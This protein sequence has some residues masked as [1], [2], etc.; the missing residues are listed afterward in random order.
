VKFCSNVYGNCGKRLKHSLIS[1][2]CLSKPQINQKLQDLS[3]FTN[4]QKR[5]TCVKSMFIHQCGCHGWRAFVVALP[6]LLGI[7]LSI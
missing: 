1:G 3:K 4:L 5:Y 6:Q 2:M 7:F